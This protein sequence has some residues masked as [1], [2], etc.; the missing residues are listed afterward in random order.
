MILIEYL[1]DNDVQLSSKGMG[2]MAKAIRDVFDPVD[3]G[4]DDESLVGRVLTYDLEE[5]ECLKIIELTTKY[6]KLWI[7]S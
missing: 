5:A 6:A 3:D 1:R 4:I 7:F 2:A